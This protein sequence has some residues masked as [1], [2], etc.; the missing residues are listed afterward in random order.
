ML[1]Y[2]NRWLYRSHKIIWFVSI[3][4]N[5]LVTSVGNL[6]F[7]SRNRNSVFNCAFGHICVWCVLAFEH[8]F[9]K[10]CVHACHGVPFFVFSDFGS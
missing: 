3:V 1:S 10:V 4:L 8:V 6:P 9:E 7:W 5:V 2:F